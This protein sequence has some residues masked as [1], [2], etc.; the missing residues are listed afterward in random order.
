MDAA[1]SMTD[2]DEMTRFEARCA[3]PHT[4]AGVRCM[5]SLPLALDGKCR[6]AIGMND[7]TVDVWNMTDYTCEKSFDVGISYKG[8]LVEMHGMHAAL[9][10]DLVVRIMIVWRN[11]M[12]HVWNLNTGRRELTIK[13]GQCR[14]RNKRPIMCPLAMADEVPRAVITADNQRILKVYNLATGK[15]E[16]QLKGHQRPILGVCALPI[17]SDGAVRAVTGSA[18]GTLKVWNTRTGECEQ[19]LIAGIASWV[20]SV[21]ALPLLSDGEVRVASGHDYESVQ[22]WNLTTGK[23]EQTLAVANSTPYWTAYIYVLP[24]LDDGNVRIVSCPLHTTGVATRVWNVTTGACE[25]EWPCSVTSMCVLPLTQNRFSESWILQIVTSAA[26]NRLTLWSRT[27]RKRPWTRRQFMTLWATAKSR[28][29]RLKSC[30]D[31]SKSNDMTC[32]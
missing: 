4:D 10:P 27:V 29:K 12:A 6:V 1:A 9:W 24:V 30:D 19:T 26:S 16:M 25:Q 20:C 2:A 7:G 5:C 23:R 31:V 14:L 3:L 17:L 32:D 13:G 18:D 28:A 15:C 11:N 8:T 22:I 21:C